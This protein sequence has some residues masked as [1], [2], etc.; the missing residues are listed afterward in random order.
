MNTEIE[1][2]LNELEQIVVGKRRV[3]E[4]IMVGMLANGHILIEDIPGMGKTKMVKS[5]ATVINC[6]YGRVQCTPDVLP[7]DIV[8]FNVFNPK[9][10]KFEYHN[11]VW[12]VQML[13]VDEINRMSAKAQSSLLELMEERQVTVEGETYKVPNP[14][15]VFATQNPYGSEGTYKLPEA[16]MDRFF[17]RLRLG[18]PN[19]SETLHILQSLLDNQYEKKALK[20]SSVEVLKKMQHEVK[21]IKVDNKLLQLI[22]NIVEQTRTHE[23][24]KIGVSTRGCINLVR[25]VQANAYIHGRSYA[26]PEDL[27]NIIIPVLAHRIVMHYYSDT[28]QEEA[29]IK[30][31]VEKSIFY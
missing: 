26:I 15:I 14:F 11:G 10:Q 3:F 30:E 16:Q 24:I 4:Q 8:G 17:M 31:I 28:E 18:Y 20:V 25:G 9:T 7:S 19:S 21:Q 29:V 22:I 27:K 6:T 23:A 5:L 1:K 12:D 2:I 13:L